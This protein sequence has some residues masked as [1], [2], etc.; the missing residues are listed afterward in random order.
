MAILKGHK[1]SVK[2]VAFNNDATILASASADNTI[3][4]WSMKTLEEMKT[5]KGHQESVNSICFNNNEKI[6]ASGSNDNTIK[7][8]N[9]ETLK[10][11]AEF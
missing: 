4:I 7:L 6:L 10:E 9:M 8:W 2:S 1:T 3:K 11:M 5:L